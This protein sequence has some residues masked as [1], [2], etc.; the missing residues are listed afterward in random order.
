MAMGKGG[1]QAADSGNFYESRPYQGNIRAII[2]AGNTYYSSGFQG[3]HI[4]ETVFLPHGFVVEGENAV[5]PERKKLG[6]S[7]YLE[8]YL[9]E[10]VYFVNEEYVHSFLPGGN[11]IGRYIGFR[12]MVVA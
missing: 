2:A 11:S 5:S 3:A 10:P 9:P 7:V 6:K 8:H 12:F 1:S 4:E